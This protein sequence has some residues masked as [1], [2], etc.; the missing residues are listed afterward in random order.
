MTLKPIHK[1]LLASALASCIGLIA[2]A[3]STTYYKPTSKLSSGHWVKIKVTN[4]GMH[5]I[6]NEQLKEM[7]F[8][9]PSKVSV[10]GYGGVTLTD[11]TFSSTLPDDLP[12]QPVYRTN[13]K[14]IF[15]GESDVRYDISSDAFTAKRIRN[16]YASAGYYFLSDVTPGESAEPATMSYNTASSSELTFH[17]SI[18]YIEYEKTC[19]ANAGSRFFGENFKE[20]PT[21]VFTFNASHPYE[22]TSY[23]GVFRYE[24]AA[25]SQSALGLSVETNELTTTYTANREAQAIS[26]GSKIY[27][28]TK[29]GIIKFLMKEDETDTV[30]T[31]TCSVPE[32]KK[33]SYAAIDY[34]TFAYYRQNNIAG[35]P[36]LRMVFREVNTSN[37]ITVSG[38]DDNTQIWNVSNPNNVFAY[39][40]RFNESGKTVSATF[41]KKYAQASNGHAYIIAFDPDKELYPVEYAGDVANQDIHSM[42]TPDLLVITNKTM[43]KYAEEIAQTHRDYQ[44]LTVH[45]IDQ[46]EIFNEFSSG[47]PAAMAYRRIAKMFYD[48][49]SSKFKYL[50]L[51]GGGTFDNRSAIIDNKDN[52]LTYQCEDTYEMNSPS[53]SYCADSYFGMLNDDFATSNIHIEPMLIGVGRIPVTDEANAA[54]VTAK[55]IG[56]LKNPPLNAAAN[57]ALLL[58]D[59]GDYDGHMFQVEEVC[60]T[61][62]HFAPHVTITKAYNS[63]YPWNFEDAAQARDVIIQ[64]F[65]NGVNYFGFTGHGTLN[66]FA[67]EILW[68]KEYVN[69]T[70]YSTPPIAMLATCD[71]LAFDR[72]D[73]GIGEALLYKDNGGSIA[74]V[75]AGRTVYKDCNQYLNLAFAAEVY[76]ASATD[77]IG[78]AYRRAHNNAATAHSDPDLGINTLCYN[79]AGDPA[80]PLYAPTLKVNTTAINDETVSSDDISVLYSLYPLAKNNI[81]GSVTDSDG[82]TMSS[83]N[84][85]VT[86]SVY[87]APVEVTTYDREATDTSRVITRDEDILTETTVKVINGTFNAELVIPESLRPGIASRIVYYAVSD[88]KEQRANGMFD[89]VTISTFDEEKAITDTTAPVISEFYIDEPT[90]CNGDQVGCDIT[91]YAT[92]LPDESGLNKTTATIG[93]ASKLI[94]DGIKSYPYIRSTLVT[95]MDGYTTIKFPINE[96]EDG[97][98]TLTLS[99]ADNAGNRTERTI[100]FVTINH[101]AQATLV[102]AEEPARSEANFS[103]EHNFSYEPQGRLVIEDATGNTVF[104]KENCTFPYTWNLLD[105]EGNAV[106]DGNYNCYAILNGN[107]QYGSTPKTRLVIVK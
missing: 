58:A 81:Q 82:N 29:D 72:L 61:I 21:Q 87:D 44:D 6:T 89:L 52:L 60:D 36:Q 59:D 9:D 39:A 75:G 5:Q 43:R 56:Y 23:T 97:K 22:P 51:F 65:S 46:E 96:L 8:S 71:A 106:A 26:S 90:F 107:K 32:T 100:S 67:R 11:N 18:Q 66:S 38:A 91:V 10:Y 41:E 40:T 86:L 48:R 3:Y 77:C 62:H 93:V 70:D 73:N 14:I 103:L 68:N 24:F 4:V 104:S 7:G 88:D 79:L 42:T 63:M 1:A 92:I 15:Y 2:N 57:K 30:Y 98:H 95:D 80:I 34:A 31:F 83:F 25:N 17:N 55:I 35:L 78:D 64:A 74:V 101:S 20:K 85:T 105:S 84:G 12:A 47:T 99:V 49:N 45:V 27:Y 102:I 19:P 53:T 28:T 50:M 54:K 16:H 94:L 33:F 13:D 37:Y 69:S 76:S